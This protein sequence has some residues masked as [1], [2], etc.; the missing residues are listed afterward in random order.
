LFCLAGLGNPGPKYR[1]TRHNAGFLAIDRI[2]GQL[3]LTP[4]EAF[5]S[6]FV[7]TCY[8]GKD[9]ILIKPQT[10]MNMS[11]QA[12]AEVVNYYKIE[13]SKL[14]IIYDDLDLKL[15]ATRLRLSGSAGGHRGLG[16]VIDHLKTD[17]FPRLRIGIGRPID[18]T[19]IVEY[20]L[21]TVE[22]SLQTEFSDGIDRAVEAGLSFVTK[23]PELTMNKF[24]LKK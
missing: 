13:I 9:M 7:K 11:G 10:F 16:S 6:I 4:K 3:E 23:G 22:E 18:G 1:Y 24:N 14:L 20:V 21:T 5:H 8:Q 17:Q 12:V 15:G 19:A 2:M